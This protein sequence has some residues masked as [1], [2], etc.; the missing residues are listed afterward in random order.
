MG[1][2]EAN[3]RWLDAK[4]VRNQVVRLRRWLERLDLVGRQDRIE[5][6]RKSGV[7]SC[8]RATSSVEFVSAASVKPASPSR[9][10]AGSASGWGGRRRSPPVIRLAASSSSWTPWAVATIARAARP[11][12][13]KST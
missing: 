8:S 9:V 1:G 6:V 11:A 13:P 7:E 4:G 3:A 5:P 10:S 2:D 12:L